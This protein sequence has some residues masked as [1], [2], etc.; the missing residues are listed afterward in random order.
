MGKKKTEEYE[1]AYDLFCNSG[2]NQT[3]IVKI[4]DVSAKQLGKWIKENDWELDKAAQQVTA[5]KLIREWYASISMINKQAADEKRPLNITEVNT[6]SQITNNIEKLRK[7]YNLS[8]YHGV[9]REFLEWE[10]K[11][12]GGKAKI[13]APEMFEFLKQKS[14]ELNAT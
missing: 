1:K 10:M 5:P 14:K 7:R 12:D 4:V 2:L 11:A 9:L 8:N 6:I 3:E 13:F